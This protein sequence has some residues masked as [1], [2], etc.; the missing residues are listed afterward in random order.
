MPESSVGSV[1]ARLRVA[2]MVDMDD[3]YRYKL[4][5]RYAVDA[6]AKVENMKTAVEEPLPQ[7]TAC[8]FVGPRYSRIT[9]QVLTLT[10][11]ADDRAVSLREE[12]QC[13]LED[14]EDV[15]MSE[16]VE[17]DTED[18]VLV[19]RFKKNGKGSTES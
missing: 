16:V 19:A 18:F 5:S 4:R 11:G 12:L 6:E 1:L 8:E 2:G 9:L 13:V 17:V 10:R 3:F 15:K 7:E 14:Y